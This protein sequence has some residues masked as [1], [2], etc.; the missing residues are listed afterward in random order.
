MNVLQF[1]GAV[2]SE[3]GTP[4][5][6]PPSRLNSVG[7]ISAP[8]LT[9]HTTAAFDSTGATALLLFVGTHNAVGQTISVTDSQGNTW[10]PLAAPQ[11][12]GSNFELDA[13]YYCN[14]PSNSAALTVTVTLNTGKSLV[15]HVTAV[16]GSNVA[17]MPLASG[18]YQSPTTASVVAPNLKVPANCLL[19][20]WVKNFQ[21]AVNATAGTGYT[22]D[23]NSGGQFLYAE[24]KQQAVGGVVGATMTL[25]QSVDLFAAT[26]AVLSVAAAPVQVFADNFHRADSLGLGSN[27]TVT[28]V[29]GEWHIISNQ[30]TVNTG[31]NNFGFIVASNPNEPGDDM[32]ASITLGALASGTYLGIGFRWNGTTG[33]RG[34]VSP[35]GTQWFLHF[36][37]SDNSQVMV[38]NM[39][40]TAGPGD[41]FTVEALGE[42]LTLRLNG[43][44]L[45]TADNNVLASGTVGLLSYNDALLA[46]FSAFETGNL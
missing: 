41:V 27:W 24:Y 19:L 26:V 4:P 18:V 42:W 2:A 44:A 7:Y 8:A 12:D 10:L 5:A 43:V 36:F 15:M 11:V 22:L 45:G 28:S 25:D 14:N 16:S 37:G 33:Y 9:V 38:G 40:V 13:I 20:S 23:P 17:L 21:F 39:P 29:A 31:A 6:V 3:G 32:Y 30:A 46:D 35:D 34:L 1:I